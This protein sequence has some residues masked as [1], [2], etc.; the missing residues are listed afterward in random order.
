[1]NKPHS[2][3]RSKEQVFL[4]CIEQD[5]NAQEP[6]NVCPTHSNRS[7]PALSEY[8]FLLHSR[9]AN[10]KSC[11]ATWQTVQVPLPLQRL[12]PKTRREFLAA[13]SCV[14]YLAPQ[15]SKNYKKPC[16]YKAYKEFHHIHFIDVLFLKLSPAQRVDDKS[17]V[18][19][20]L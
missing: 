8:S 13:I 16:R 4:I 15:S 10:G 6:P 19:H 18:A 9:G 5:D 7:R 2:Y 17:F 1:M 11:S 14:I 12:L 20:H 3:A